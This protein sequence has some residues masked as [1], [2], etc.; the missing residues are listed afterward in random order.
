M[1]AHWLIINNIYITTITTLL[2]TVRKQQVDIN[3]KNK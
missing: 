1:P 2:V 3:N